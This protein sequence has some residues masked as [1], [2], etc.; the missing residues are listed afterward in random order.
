M[1]V[2]MMAD[3][4]IM[5]IFYEEFEGSNFEACKWVDARKEEMLEYLW[6]L[7]NDII[8]S[9]SRKRIGNVSVGGKVMYLSI[10]TDE[11]ES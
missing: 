6:L 11:K 5:P 10:T 9:F 8:C 3:L 2:R 1:K 4:R 7:S